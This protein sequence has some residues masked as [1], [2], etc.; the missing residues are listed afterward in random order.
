MLP[1]HC[2]T[3]II[4]SDGICFSMYRQSPGIHCHAICRCPTKGKMENAS[5]AHPRATQL[6]P[7]SSSEQ[8]E[9]VFSVPQLAHNR[10]H[11]PHL[12][13]LHREPR[14]I[15]RYRETPSPG[16]PRATQSQPAAASNTEKQRRRKQEEQVAAGVT[17]G[18]FCMK[19][20]REGAGVRGDRGG[21]YHRGG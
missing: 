9:A 10:R 15:A 6:K 4:K 3:A 21:H 5:L 14:S 11:I 17:T 19:P 8:R 12:S 16:Q 18:I 20:M 2:Q 13:C 1:T 7:G